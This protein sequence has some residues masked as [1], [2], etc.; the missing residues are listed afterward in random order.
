MLLEKIENQDYTI[1]LWAITENKDELLEILNFYP[2]IIE[3]ISSFNSEKRILEY[4]S[5]RCALKEV[6]PDAI[7]TYNEYGKPFIKDSEYNISI[8]HTGTFA[9]II[10]S[11][12]KNV[13]ID[14]ER[15]TE[16]VSR[17]KYKFLSEGELSN[18]D[19]KSERTHLALNW[20]AKEAIYKIS[21]IPQ[22]S[23]FDITIE[24][25]QPYLN[26]EFTAKVKTNEELNLQYKVY[27]DFVLVW[28]IK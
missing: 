25:F 3:Q 7:I 17:V 4:L 26:G 5:V 12:T 10:L 9:T 18:I 19:E 13:G 14:I 27:R 20:A 1:I 6:L 24:K 23:F 16:R 28:T 21:N 2:D 8:S 22:L 11:K 15:I